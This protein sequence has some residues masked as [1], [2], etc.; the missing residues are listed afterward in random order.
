M[1]ISEFDNNNIAS[2]LDGS[3]DWYTAHVLRF[4]D[5]VIF[6]ADSDNFRWLWRT[7]PEECTLIYHHYGWSNNDIAD[8][9]E[10]AGV[11]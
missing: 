4:L 5:K 8:R 2:I 11:I 10:I 3:G 9:L 7:Y 6:K 1:S